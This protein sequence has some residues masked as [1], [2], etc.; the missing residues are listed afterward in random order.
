MDHSQYSFLRFSASKSL[1]FHE[2][3]QI[4]PSVYPVMHNISKWPD[5]LQKSCSKCCKF[6]KCVW[7]FLDVMPQRDKILCYI[8]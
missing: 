7:P 4:T 1:T 5:T 2:T 8:M 3:G 6:L